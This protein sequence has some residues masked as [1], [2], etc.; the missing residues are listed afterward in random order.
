MDDKRDYWR[1]L[2]YFTTIVLCVSL[3]FT[4][5]DGQPLLYGLLGLFGL[6]PGIPTGAN[7]TLYIY[8]LI[9]IA[10]II[11]SV[12]KIL[13]YWHG[14][15]V[16]FRTFNPLLRFFPVVIAGVALAFSGMVFSPSLVDR[17][18]FANVSRQSGLQ[19]VTAFSEEN[20]MQWRFDGNVQAYSADLMLKNHG[21]E[22]VAFY[23]KLVLDHLNESI[24]VQDESGNARE[25][26]LHPGQH[27][28][29]VGDFVRV[30]SS[31]WQGGG[32]GTFTVELFN[33]EGMRRLTPLVRRPV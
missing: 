14:Y 20:Q 10:L 32:R 25:F 29:H 27:A 24:V 5:P 11:M 13:K 26:I 33:A 8:P 19:A 6:S 9:P 23:V 22:T 3:T 12:T 16:R 17:L 30:Y 28:W 21:D 15:S 1:G 31:G 2:A 7:S 18:Y 4:T